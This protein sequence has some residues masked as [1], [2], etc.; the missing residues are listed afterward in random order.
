[1]RGFPLAALCLV[2][3][4][5]TARASDAGAGLAPGHD[6]LT[7]PN[8]E[9]GRNEGER[10]IAGTAPGVVRWPVGEGIARESPVGRG[11]QPRRQSGGTVSATWTTLHPGRPVTQIGRASCR[12]RVSSPV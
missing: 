7:P 2:V 4:P 11:R 5:V 10:H 12:E 6:D 1:M 3:A 8:G 9:G